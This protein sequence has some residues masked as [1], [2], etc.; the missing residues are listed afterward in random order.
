MP[1]ERPV[2]DA[3]DCHVHI[4]GSIE[5]YPQITSRSYTA[6]PATVDSLR[7]IAEPQGVNRFVLVQPSFYGTDNACL[8]DALE[9]LG[10]SAR[11]VAVVDA[12]GIEPRLLRECGQRGVRGLRV[13]LY[14]GVRNYPPRYLD[15]VLERTAGILPDASWHLEIIAPLPMLAAAA[16]TIAHAEATIVIDHY[17]LPGQSV[18]DSSEG[19]CLLELAAL[20]RVW[21][22]LSAPY[23]ILN[24][25]LATV[26]P[27]DWLKALVEAAPE[28]C[29]WGSDWPHTPARE[30]RAGTNRDAAYRNIDYGQA[31]ESFCAALAEPDLIAQ[32]L[33]A[34]PRR[35]FG[36]PA[37]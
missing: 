16:A 6:G 3:C 29:V 17:G 33:T 18:P 15:R 26:P 23:R 12:E 21:I 1:I 37:D 22:K 31:L 2:A 32:I 27:A 28:R 24:D 14:S 20:P 13:N 36:F 30:D 5:H 9:T 8:L 4:V 25:P 35:L 10:E 34:N 19:R 7:K 11:G